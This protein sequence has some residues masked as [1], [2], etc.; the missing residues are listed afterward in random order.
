MDRPL[1]FESGAPGRRRAQPRKAQNV[2]VWEKAAF[3][4]GSQEI[5]LCGQKI[6]L[7]ARKI[8]LFLDISSYISSMRR[9]EAM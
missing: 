6:G 2:Y 3:Q 4:G 7:D 9:A 8:C 5:G 1:A